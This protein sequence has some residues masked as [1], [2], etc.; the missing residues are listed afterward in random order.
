MIREN[1]P[2][3]LVASEMGLD[4]PSRDLVNIER[5][6]SFQETL[7]TERHKYYASLASS[8]ERTK[9][10]MLGA[11]T[12][13]IDHLFKEGKYKDAVDA[14]LKLGKLEGW[15]GVEVQNVFAMLNERQLREIE[16]QLAGNNI[17]KGFRG[18]AKEVQKPSGSPASSTEN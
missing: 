1:K 18:T 14:I 2:L 6:K 4:I 3:V 13:A 10:A 9:Q 17:P 8:P 12:L 16:E 7:W 11:A 15:V 5:R